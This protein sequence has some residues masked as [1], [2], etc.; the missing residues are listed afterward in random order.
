VSTDIA[1]QENPKPPTLEEPIPT[2][3]GTP[4]LTLLRSGTAREL[5]LTVT[6]IERAQLLS[7]IKVIM[8][9]TS[10]P[11]TAQIA[12]ALEALALHYPVLTRTPAEQTV[13]VKHWVE[14]LCDVPDD[15]I[16]EACRLWRRSPADRFSTPGQLR[17]LID[18]ILEVRLAYRKR[19]ADFMRLCE[20]AEF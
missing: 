15:L 10:H 17:K 3:A 9:A 16:H 7:A 1:R 4:G 6:P 8:A 14:D 12:T 13:V 19:A 18:P 20:D 2:L 11:T 5:F